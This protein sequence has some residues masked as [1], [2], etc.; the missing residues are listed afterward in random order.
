M[1]IL[2]PTYC[3]CAS[4]CASLGSDALALLK[5]M[6]LLGADLENAQ[7]GARV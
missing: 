3:E 5:A 6:K 1:L 2:H 7:V 4:C